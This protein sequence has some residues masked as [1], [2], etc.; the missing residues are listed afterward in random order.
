M[1]G[2]RNSER[3]VDYTPTKR[4]KGCLHFDPH[5]P[6]TRSLGVQ[7]SP[8][9]QDGRQMAMWF[10]LQVVHVA[11]RQRSSNHIRSIPPSGLS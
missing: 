3:F 11:G 7:I 2:N 4:G 1:I 9:Q 5:S 10:M 8:R 6:L